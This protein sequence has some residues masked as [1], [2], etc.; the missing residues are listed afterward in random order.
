MIRRTKITDT[1]LGTL[2]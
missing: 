2:R 1:P